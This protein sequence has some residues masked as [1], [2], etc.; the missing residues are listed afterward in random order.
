MS[1]AYTHLTIANDARAH[2]RKIGLRKTTLAALGSHLKYVE[3]GAVSPDYPYLSTDRSQGRWA[4]AMHITRTGALFR[5]AVQAI[6]RAPGTSQ[7]RLIAWLFGWASHVATDMT[8]HPV[9]ELKVGPYLGNEKAHRI[10]EMHQDA[11]LFPRMNVGSAALSQHL[12]TGVATCN[13][14]H[15]AD[16]LDPVIEAVW[17][18]ALLETYPAHAAE[19]A[20]NPSGWHRGF[21]RVLAL[22]AGSNHLFP[23]ARHVGISMGLNYPRF[24]EIDPQYIRGLQTPEGAMDLDPLYER[25]RANVLEIWRGLD[26]ALVSGRSDA[27]DALEDWNLDTGRSLAT[28]QLVLWSNLA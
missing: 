21:R 16:A 12:E 28:Q 9:I 8:I 10:C 4:D 3:L 13:A 14:P 22:V 2:A 27:L 6:H 17:L 25:A 24:D 19:D 11:H 15:D 26:E 23:F 1:G 20:P 7:P 18:E 5:A